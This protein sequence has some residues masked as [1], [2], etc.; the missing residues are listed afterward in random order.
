[1]KKRIL[2]SLLFAVPGFFFSLII[3]FALT[4]FA[5]GFFWIFV[6]GDNPWPESIGTILPLL[7]I[8]FFLVPW[9]LSIWVGFTTGKRLETEPELNKKH[10]LV[11][12][13]L[14]IVPILLIALHQLNVG[15]IGPKTDGQ[16][17]NEICQQKG[18]SASAMVPTES[19]DKSCTCFDDSGREVLNIPV[20]PGLREKDSRQEQPDESKTGY[21]CRVIFPDIRPVKLS[22]KDETLSITPTILGYDNQNDALFAVRGSSRAV[23]E[24]SNEVVLKINGE[25]PDSNFS[26]MAIE[27]SCGEDVY[28]IDV[29]IPG[30]NTWPDAGVELLIPSIK[31][32]FNMQ[33]RYHSIQQKMSMVD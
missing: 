15:N 23:H 6:F 11:S 12:V 24:F 9:L 31:A 16:L 20:E 10:V 3:A 17:C 4:G 33:I 8:L 19:S 21:Y 22:Y 1:M 25:A 18:Y 26:L 7:M 14:T 32:M 27:T 2:Y 5:A 29:N 28:F 30:L 13:C